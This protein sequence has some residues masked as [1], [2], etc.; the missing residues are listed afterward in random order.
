M[1]IEIILDANLTPAELAEIAVVAEQGGIRTQLIPPFHGLDLLFD[2]PLAAVRVISER[3]VPGL[4]P[5]S[6][7]SRTEVYRRT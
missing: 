5:P 7:S 4:R 6:A 3:V 2:E 1:D